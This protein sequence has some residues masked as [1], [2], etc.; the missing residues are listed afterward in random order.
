MLWWYIPSQP[1]HGGTMVVVEL[2]WYGGIFLPNQFMVVYDGGGVERQ[3]EL[4]VPQTGGPL[5]TNTTVYQPTLYQHRTNFAA[6][7]D[8]D[9]A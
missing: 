6:G 7:G 8:E 3:T 4:W 1:V 5:C 2:K 9:K